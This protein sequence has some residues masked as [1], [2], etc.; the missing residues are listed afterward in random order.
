MQLGR[1][2]IITQEHVDL[3]FE[4]TSKGGSQHMVARAC[5]VAPR[6][7][8]NWI[9]DARKGK[10]SQLHMEFLRNINKGTLVAERHALAMIVESRE[11]RDHQWWLTHHPETRDTWSDVA[12][13][14]KI[15]ENTMTSVLESITAAGLPPDTERSILL[16]MQ[17]R[18]LGG[19]IETS[20][21]ETN[22]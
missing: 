14:Q 22:H 20:A 1:P 19:A 8:E 16:Q 17:A 2:S 18:G 21:D 3:A 5:G 4:I 15:V 9:Q 13:K 11:P 10:G 12:M 7:V 6:T